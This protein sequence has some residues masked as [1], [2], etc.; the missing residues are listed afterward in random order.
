MIDTDAYMRWLLEAVRAAGCG[1]VQ[2]KVSGNLLEQ[3]STL[4]REFDAAILVNCAG[5]GARAL[6]DASVFPLRGALVR[7][8]NDGKRMPRLSEAHCVADD[9]PGRFVFVVPRGEDMMVLGGLAEPEEWGLDV[10]LHNYEPIRQMYQRC[11]EFLPALAA[12]Q[13]DPSEQVRVG[14]RPFRAGGAR[15]EVDKSDSRIVHNYGH[16]G[17]GITLSWGCAAEVANLVA[18][19]LSSAKRL[20]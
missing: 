2:R 14:L 12:A 1:I 15:L 20:T 11:V 6:G 10:G 9:G 8:R 19:P 17:S 4:R 5:L 16:G 13:I 18:M 3:A 7:I